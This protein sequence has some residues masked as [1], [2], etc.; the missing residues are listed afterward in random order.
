[1]ILSISRKKNRI[2]CATSEVIENFID[3]M[4]IPEY[5]LAVR[6][7]DSNNSPDICRMFSETMMLLETTEHGFM[8]DGGDPNKIYQAYIWISTIA[9]DIERKQ[10]EPQRKV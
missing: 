7:T 10:N 4:L 5:I 3:N 1:M 6:T 2:I 8:L 9:R